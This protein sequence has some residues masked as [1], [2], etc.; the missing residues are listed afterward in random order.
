[1]QG[2]TNTSHHSL[3]D[4]LI[5]EHFYIFH[6]ASLLSKTDD[7]A[8]GAKLKIERAK[9][10]VNDLNRE[11]EAFM[12]QKP[13]RLI[14]R[15]DPKSATRTISIK[16]YCPIPEQISLI[17]GDA[18]HNM[19]SALD[20]LIFSMIGHLV[21]NPDGLYFPIAKSYDRLKGTLE[22]RQIKLAGENVVAEIEALE[23][24]PGGCEELWELQWLDVNDKH[25]I[26][27]PVG[28]V[29]HL[30]ASDINKID[31]S[32]R[33]FG[34]KETFIVPIQPEIFIIQLGGNRAARRAI[35]PFA[36]ETEFQPTF[37]L[38]FGES[39]PFQFQPILPTLH[40]LIRRVE[41]AI[42]KIVGA[43]NH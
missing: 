9:Q 17:L 21:T 43:Y 6:G 33:I 36:K 10:H 12:A 4:L 40:R 7:V 18:I 13:F 16:T 2:S 28:M 37:I 27:I 19:R 26:I 1:M 14:A 41:R 30:A 5:G 24:Y 20:L 35:V 32:I 34:T 8:Y 31:S 3:L 42:E 38:C 22:S 15:Q 23:P 25:K 11:M 39:Q 29:P